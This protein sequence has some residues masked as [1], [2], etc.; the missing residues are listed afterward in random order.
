MA[1]PW[2]LSHGFPSS[3]GTWDQLQSGYLSGGR[4]IQT[5]LLGGLVLRQSRHPLAGPTNGRFLARRLE[6]IEGCA[7]VTMID[8]AV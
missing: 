4:S 2:H 5:P 7:V 1:A 6:R 8:D 3:L